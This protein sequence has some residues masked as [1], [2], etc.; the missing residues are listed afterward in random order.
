M[1]QRIQTLFFILSILFLA[2]YLYV[3]NYTQILFPYVLAMISMGSN[4]LAIFAYLKRKRQLLFS[5][6]S[7]VS[8]FAIIAMHLTDLIPPVSQDFDYSIIFLVSSLIGNTLANFFIR[9]DIKLI[10]DARRLR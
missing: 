4:L 2:T 8:I 10:E 9:K 6:I 3:L 5:Y 7:M 1:I